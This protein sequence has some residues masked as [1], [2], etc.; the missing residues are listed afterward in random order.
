MKNEDAGDQKCHIE[1]ECHMTC[2]FFEK[3]HIAT[4]NV[5]LL[6]A[7]RGVFVPSEVEAKSAVNRKISYPILFIVFMWGHRQVRKLCVCGATMAS[8]LITKKV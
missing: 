6:G 4:C 5:A 8:F 7:I 3:C 2:R 1:G